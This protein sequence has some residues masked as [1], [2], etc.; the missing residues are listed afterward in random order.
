MMNRQE[1]LTKIRDGLAGLSQED[2]NKSVDYY[3]EM[4]DDRM[5]EGLTEDEAIEALGSADVIVSSILIDTPLPKLVKAKVTPSRALRVWEII[6]II[7]GFPL[8]GSLLL[9]G[10]CIV[11]AVYMVIFSA[12]VFMYAV[13]FA[14]AASV[15]GGV[16]SAVVIICTGKGIAGALFML[17]CGIASAGIAI[18]LFLAFNKITKE[19]GILSKNIWIGIKRCFVGKEDK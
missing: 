1:F 9:A 15:A 13:D 16:W 4:I 3:C 2:I 6:L 5:E 19:I 11:F 12:V 18:L 8:W 10:V 7:L 17:G 14:F